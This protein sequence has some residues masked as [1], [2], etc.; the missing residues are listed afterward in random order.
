METWNGDDVI[1]NLARCG[2]A[3]VC[4]CRCRAPHLETPTADNTPPATHF[5]SAPGK[6]NMRHREVGIELQT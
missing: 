4:S 3:V 2:F 6:E 5:T 1:K